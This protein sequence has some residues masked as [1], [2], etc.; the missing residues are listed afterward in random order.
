MN[1][2]VS[3]LGGLLLVLVLLVAG[4][5]SQRL[6]E[7]LQNLLIFDLLVRLELL[8]AGSGGV[9]EL[10]DTVLGDGYE[11]SEDAHSNI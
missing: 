8:R 7:D 4:R 11:K 10:G 2:R 5:A 6:L 3:L 9:G 1:I